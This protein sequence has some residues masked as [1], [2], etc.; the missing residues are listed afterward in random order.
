M[1]KLVSVIIPVYNV[2]KYLRRCLDSVVSQTYANL[3]IIIV[4]DGSPDGSQAI[5]DQY[6]ARDARI[7]TRVQENRTIGMARNAGMDMA[8]GDYLAFVDSDD[9]LEPEAIAVMLDNA[10]DT[11]ADIVAANNRVLDGE[12]RCSRAIGDRPLTREETRDPAWRF[13]YFIAPAYGITAWGKLYRHSFIKETGIRFESNH[14][15]SGE[16]ILF[17]LLLFTHN[18]QLSL[19]NQHV[20]VYCLNEGSITHSYRP[21]LAP[22]YLALLDIYRRQ[23]VQLDQLEE[24]R[25]LMAFLVLRFISTCCHNEYLYAPDRYAA[26]KGQLAELM[27]SDIVQSA[28]QEVARGDHIRAVSTRNHTYTRLQATLL[29]HG[30]IGAVARLRMLRLSFM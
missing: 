24:F 2:E 13:V 17:N 23:L 21:R 14:R 19:L 11:G 3:E 1:E 5:I 30:M 6:A 16:D 22:I 28:L 8:R 20:Y 12:L 27:G 10:L 29:R 15:I 4:N 7:R 18:P 26:I 9:Y 25:D